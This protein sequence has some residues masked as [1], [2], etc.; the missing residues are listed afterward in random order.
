[1][2]ACCVVVDVVD[3]VIDVMEMVLVIVVIRSWWLL[4]WKCR[5]WYSLLLWLSTGEVGHSFV[6]CCWV[7]LSWLS[8]LKL[9]LLL[10]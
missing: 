9:C 2:V 8:W 7:L 1:M 10:S 3:V 6:S 5:L 4:L